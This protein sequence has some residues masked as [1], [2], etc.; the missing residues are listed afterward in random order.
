MKNLHKLTLILIATPL[1]AYADEQAKEQTEDALDVM[2]VTATKTERNIKDVGSAVT[3]IDKEQ[4]SKSTA[5]TADQLLRGVAGVYAS[6]MD[7]SSPNRIAQTYTRGLPGNGRT[8]VLIDDVPMNVSYDSQVDWSQLGT[9]DL[10]RMEIVRGAGSALYGNHAMGGVINILTKSISPGFKGQVQSEY[11]SWDTKRE[12][13]SVSFG[14]E[15]T[16]GQISTSYLE[17]AGYNMWRPDTPTASIPLTLRDKTGTQKTNVAAKLTHEFDSANLL[18][19]NFSYLSDVTTGLYTIPNLIPQDREQYLSSL[20]YRHQGDKYDATLLLYSRVG[21][22]R[23]DSANVFPTAAYPLANINYIGHFNDM[24]NGLRTQASYYLD[25]HHKLTL[26]GQYANTQMTMV[27]NDYLTYSV[28]GLTLAHTP[29]FGYVNQPNRVQSTGGTNELSAIFLQDEINYGP[30]NVN[31]AG[32]WDHWQTN[33]SF[34]DPGYNTPGVGNFADRSADSL[35]PK[36]SIAYKFNED[37]VFRGSIGK[38]FNTPDISQM[39][40]TVTRG[41]TLVYGNPNLKPETAVSSD[42]GIDYYFG[43]Q[44]YFK[45]TIYNT[46]AQ[47]FVS[48][49]TLAPIPNYTTVKQNINFGGVRVQ[50][51]EIEGMWKPADLLTLHA[52]YTKNDSTVTQFSQNPAVVGKQLTNVPKDQGYLRADFSLPYGLNAFGTYNFVGDRYINETN[53][54][55]ASSAVYKAYSTYDLGFSKSLYKD[56]TARMTF[57]NITNVKYEGIGYI[58]PGATIMGGIVAKF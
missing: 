23:A 30:V 2:V 33:G 17:S 5:T 10:E 34:T 41:T 51:I 47:N 39:Y 55:S 4:I 36:G 43:K 12:A 9:I 6:R 54:I 26:G 48:T 42:L 22:M 21:V 15:Q 37:L 32:R 1:L 58:A 35:S 31:L 8:L 11:G 46:D 44:A 27:N 45:T 29:I 14:G 19:L 40:G 50:G 38:S 18:T 56:I 3:V 13:G 24:E 16:R 28:V 57:M 25:N 53:T 7:A 49:Q 20:K 52:S